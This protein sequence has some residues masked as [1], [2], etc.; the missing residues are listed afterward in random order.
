MGKFEIGLQCFIL[1]KKIL[2][3]VR[4]LGHVFD[5]DEEILKSLMQSYSPK[6][7]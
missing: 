2:G 6:S 1:E 4:N 5:F 3:D 7:T